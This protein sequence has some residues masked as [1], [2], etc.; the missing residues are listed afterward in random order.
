MVREEWLAI[1]GHDPRVPAAYLRERDGQI[2][3]EPVKVD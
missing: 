2:E 1:F 3:A